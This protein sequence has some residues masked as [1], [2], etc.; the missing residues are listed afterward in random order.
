MKKIITDKFFYSTSPINV[1][2]SQQFGA[3]ADVVLTCRNEVVG[4]VL[5]RLL[6]HDFTQ[7][8]RK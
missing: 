2:G 5:V 1:L 4:L 3:S 8:L 7:K 6:K